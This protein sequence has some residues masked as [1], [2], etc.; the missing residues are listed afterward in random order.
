[1]GAL[2]GLGVG[3]GAVLIVSAFTRPRA[4]RP[5]SDPVLRG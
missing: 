4:R 1:M 3:V 5:V 2:L